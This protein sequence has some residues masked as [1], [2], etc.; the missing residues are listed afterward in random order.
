M[1]HWKGFSTLCK[2]N[3]VWSIFKVGSMWLHFWPEMNAHWSFQVKCYLLVIPNHVCWVLD[4]IIWP[5]FKTVEKCLEKQR[6]ASIR[7][8]WTV[9][10][11]GKVMLTFIFTQ[12]TL[13]F[14]AGCLRNKP[15]CN[16]KKSSFF[17]KV[18]VFAL[19]QVMVTYCTAGTASV[20]WHCWQTCR[21]PTLQYLAFVPCDFWVFPLLKCE[22]Q[23]QKFDPSIKVLQ[24]TTTTLCSMSD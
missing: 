5:R 7:E 13:F 6:L 4:Q 1:L 14:S 23:G 21:A 10:S 16:F 15:E 3:Y 18:M 9:L 24:A 2:W 11:S 8:I 22:L 19:R 12:K 17:D 20:R